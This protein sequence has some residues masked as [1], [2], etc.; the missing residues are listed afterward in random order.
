MT[1][2]TW[3]PV[4]GWEGWYEVT[5]RPPQVRSV[6][7]TIIRSDGR[8]YRAKGRI[9]RPQRHPPSWVLCVTLARAG[10]KHQACVHKLVAEAFDEEKAA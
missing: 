7:R 10:H 3:L 4:V 8:P 9:L 5:N 6:D 1:D 2:E